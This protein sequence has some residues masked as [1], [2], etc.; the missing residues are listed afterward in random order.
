MEGE[1]P[2]GQQGPV[3]M[4]LVSKCFSISPPYEEYLNKLIPKLND[5]VKNF[6]AGRLA[7]HL[8]FWHKLTKDKNVL[9]TVAGLT[10]EFIRLP[11]QKFI[12]SEYRHTDE[13]MKFLD[14]EIEKLLKKGIITKV[15]SQEVQY[16]SNIF[17]R[18]KKDGSFRMILNLTDLNEVVE[19]HKFKM[20]TLNSALSLVTPNCFMGSIDFKDAYYSVAVREDHRKWLRFKFR[21]V[22]YEYTCLPN[23]LTSG[24]RLFTKITKPLFASLREKGHLNSPYF[25]DSILLGDDWEDCAQNIMDTV[26]MATDGGFVIHPEKS[27]FV[28][29]QNI[30]FLGFWINS[31]TMTVKLSSEKAQKIRQL[32]LDLLGF[33]KPTIRTVAR[34]VGKMVAAFPAVLFGKLYYRQLDNEKSLALKESHGD[35]EGKMKLSEQAKDDLNWWV[36]NIMN[37]SC[38]IVQTKPDL[39]VYSD[40]SLSGWGG[41]RGVTTTGGNWSSS[42][43]N[44]HIN[45]LELMAAYYVLAS[46][47]DEVRGAHIRLMV[48]NKTALA[49][50]NGMGGRKDVCNKMARKI[51]NWCKERDIWLS[52]AYITSEQNIVADKMSRIS[53]NNAEWALNDNVFQQICD[54]FG[55]PQLDLFASRLNFKCKRYVSWQP[56]PFAEAVDAFSLDWGKEEMLYIFPPFCVINR[57][58]QKIDFDK[59]RAVVI[60]PM[61]TTQPWWSKLLRLLTNCPF[62]FYRNGGTLSHPQRSLEELPRMLLIACTLSGKS[63]DQLRFRMKHNASFCLHGGDRHVGNTRFTS[64][65]GRNLRLGTLSIP[66]HRL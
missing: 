38:P 31:V 16:V 36:N 17:L 53:H 26:E 28:P 32:C 48:D 2:E 27:I 34:V 50:I 63:S 59:A 24:P 46:L 52:A 25:D 10:L 21:N 40:A 9:S 8:D 39:T 51:W 4:A 56:D 6:Q 55:K 3:N 44:I 62:S 18:P 5:L 35:F 54:I 37:N 20:D 13:E 42:E 22:L 49:Y 45:I 66:L 65:D 23:G 15:K 29:T 12:P 30:E 43:S 61:W 41:A 58:L 60:V 47:C 14:S 19:Y 1:W 57:V 7:R 11:V 33:R 64:K